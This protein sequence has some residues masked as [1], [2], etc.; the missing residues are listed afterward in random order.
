MSVPQTE[1]P[2]GQARIGLVEPG[3][4]QV[5]AQVLDVRRTGQLAGREAESYQGVPPV[6]KAPWEWYYIPVYFWVGGIA[7]GSWLAAAGEDIGGTNDRGV[8]RAGRYIAMG[9]TLAG[10][11]LLIADL[12]RPERFLN[13]LRIVRARSPMS[14][15]AWGL[16]A[17][18]ALTGAAAALQFAED[19]LGARSRLGRLSGGWLGR[20]VH[21]AGLPLALF[22]GGYTGVLLAATATPTWAQ[23]KLLLGPLFLTSGVAS[24]LA[25]VS[26]AVNAADSASPAARRR[27]SRGAALALGAEL[28]LESADREE[29]SKLPSSKRESGVVKTT[30]AL[31][32]GAGMIAPLAL[33]LVRGIAPVG[34]QRRRRERE[35]WEQRRARGRRRRSRQGLLAAGLT[36]AGGLALRLLSVHEGKVS[37]DTPEDTWAFASPPRPAPMPR[38][39]AGAPPLPSAAARPGAEERA[40]ELRAGASP[41]L[42]PPPGR[43]QG[44][45][46]ET[47]GG[48]A[49]SGGVEAPWERRAAD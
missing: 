23:R 46:A 16:S 49:R 11:G 25:A 12:G 27:L 38:A 10:T 33:E 34:K 4:G 5:D 14:L 30:R 1:T 24:G 19:V 8:V 3:P 44:K 7:A 13:M 28:L 47:E 17:F 42:A 9:G 20:A 35:R 36:L 32:L 37:A 2:Y 40:D 43:G 31:M 39:E 41:P 22:A 45:G 21:L 15:G 18:G 26:F 29:A 48:A 6:K